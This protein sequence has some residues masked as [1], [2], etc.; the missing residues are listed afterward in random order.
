MTTKQILKCQ[1]A[2]IRLRL[3][4]LNEQIRLNRRK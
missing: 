1:D 4:W 3:K 2:M